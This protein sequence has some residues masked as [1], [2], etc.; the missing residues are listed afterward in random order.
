MKPEIFFAANNRNRTAEV[1]RA[2]WRFMNKSRI[3]A[4]KNP[5]I[6][7]PLVSLVSAAMGIVSSTLSL[8]GTIADRAPA[9][10]SL[11]LNIRFQNLTN[12]IAVVDVAQNSNS[13]TWNSPAILSGQTVVFPFTLGGRQAGDHSFSIMVTDE[14]G[15]QS[16]SYSF[17]IT[18]NTNDVRVTRAIVGVGGWVS[19]PATTNL[20]ENIPMIYSGAESSGLPVTLYCTSVM[21]GVMNQTVNIDVSLL[22]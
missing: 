9:P 8:A 16:H 5:M 15:N 10:H 14:T 12:R 18:D 17:S 7:G 4:E 22:N 13:R 3:S 1:A 20:R 11:R 2:A 19:G 6:I 21:G